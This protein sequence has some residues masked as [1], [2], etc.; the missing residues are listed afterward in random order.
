MADLASEFHWS[1]S[2][3]WEMELDD[4]LMWYEQLD[5]IIAERQKEMS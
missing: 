4:L 3:M 5:R 1:P 2:E